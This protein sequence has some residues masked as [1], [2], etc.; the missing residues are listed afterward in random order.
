MSAPSDKKLPT[1]FFIR[2]NSVEFGGN[3]DADT[4]ILMEINSI[5][6]NQK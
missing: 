5:A 3:F 2:N 4:A 6:S 1:N